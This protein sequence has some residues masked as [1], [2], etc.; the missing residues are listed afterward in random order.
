MREFE[1]FSTSVLRVLQ[2]TIQ[3]V[4]QVYLHLHLFSLS[5]KLKPLLKM[6]LAA[7]TLACSLRS[8]KNILFH[9]KTM[10]MCQKQCK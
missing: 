5:S 9:F 3:S 2:S 6:Q 8:I 1:N 10:L 4:S 7:S